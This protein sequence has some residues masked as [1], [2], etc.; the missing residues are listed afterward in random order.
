MTENVHSVRGREFLHQA[1]TK[2]T[3]WTLPIFGN[4]DTNKEEAVVLFD[5]AAVQFKL[6]HNWNAA[7]MAYIRAADITEKF[8]KS[9]L[10]AGQ[11]YVKAAKVFKNIDLE[12]ANQWFQR[13]VAVYIEHDRLHLAAQIYEEIA[14]LEEKQTN[15]S[16]AMMAWEKAAN[17]YFADDSATKGHQCLLK[18]AHY[19]ALREEYQKSIDIYEKTASYHLNHKL[20]QY[21]TKNYQFKVCTHIRRSCLE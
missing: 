13:V 17:C 21:S 9:P 8:L 20:L 10:Q 11:Y 3:V 1:E 16:N 5:K 12:K 19:S 2:L 15:I 18:I 14:T 4:S 7:A 6:A